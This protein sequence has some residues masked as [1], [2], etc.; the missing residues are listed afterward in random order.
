MKMPMVPRYCDRSGASGAGEASLVDVDRSVGN[1][2]VPHPAPM[3]TVG[4]E[5]AVIGTRID[6]P[7]VAVGQPDEEVLTG[8]V[9][10]DQQPT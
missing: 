2:T 8:S 5:R 4:W 9:Q 7:E 6:V 3:L 10:L 1:R